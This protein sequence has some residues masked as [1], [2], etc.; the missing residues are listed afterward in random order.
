MAGKILVISRG[1]ALLPDALLSSFKGSDITAVQVEPTIKAIEPEKDNT[2]I[3]VLFA[4]DF[5]YD[6]PELLVYLKDLCFGGDKTLCVV[7]YSKE[8]NEI[9]LKEDD[10]DTSFGAV[11]RSD[12][13]SNDDEFESA[14]FRMREAGEEFDDDLDQFDS[15][16]DDYTDDDN[17]EGF[18]DDYSAEEPSDDDLFDL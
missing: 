13:R 11:E 5:V 2:N 9:E 10:E 8:M 18:E 7:G 14:G 15:S 6:S 16:D 3:F 1:T 12:Y 4:G 17:D